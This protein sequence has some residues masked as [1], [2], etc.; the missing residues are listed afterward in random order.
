MKSFTSVAA[1]LGAASS[2]SAVSIAEINGN[3]FLSPFQDK[4]VTGVTG[5]VTVVADN[6]IYLRSVQPDHDPATSEGL[7]VFSST[8]GKLVNKGDVVTMSGL[9]KEYRCVFSRQDTFAPSG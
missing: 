6:G 1:L 9:V 2:A 4:N 3:R 8:V 7:F 5:L